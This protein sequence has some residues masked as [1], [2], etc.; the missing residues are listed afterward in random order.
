MIVQSSQRIARNPQPPSPC[1]VDVLLFGRFSNHC[2]ANA[3]EPLR[4]ANALSRRTL[5]AW[6]HLTFD[7]APVESSSGLRVEPQ[8][9]LSRSD[10]GD[11]LFVMPSYG[12]READ[13]PALRA[14]LRAAARR[15]RTLV[16]FDTGAWLLAGAGLLDGRRATIHWDEHAA[17]AET[18]PAVTAEPRRVVHDG[19][20]ITCGGGEAAFELALSLIQDHHGPELRV[21][22]ATLFMRGG[23]AGGG[24]PFPVSGLERIDR[25]VA[26]MRRDLERPRRIADIARE[27]GASQRGLEAEF[28]R[29]LK[30]SPQGVYGLLR[31]EE[32]RRLVESSDLAVAEIALRCGWRSPGAMTRAYRARYGVSPRAMRAG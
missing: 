26:L 28:A 22:V 9:R 25:A 23:W 12:A 13:T 30:L 7:G 17:F 8:A 11:M 27:V 10:G 32:A 4:A 6:R 21:V 18:F 31:L 1:R 19:D 16:G 5:Y 20:R 29:H 2:L 24:R 15:Y 3:V 14:G